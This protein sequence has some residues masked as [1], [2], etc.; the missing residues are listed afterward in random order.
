MRMIAENHGPVLGIGVE[1]FEVAPV[2]AVT[3]VCD[4]VST[5]T[6]QENVNREQ[7]GC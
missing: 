4:L 7:C 6:N 3:L 5:P 1:E 2:R